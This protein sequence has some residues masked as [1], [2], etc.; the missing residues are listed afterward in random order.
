MTTEEDLDVGLFY[1]NG[2]GLSSIEV[3]AKLGQEAELHRLI[4]AV[5]KALRQGRAGWAL[6]FE[7]V[8]NN[9][10]GLNQLLLSNGQKSIGIPNAKHYYQKE[11]FGRVTDMSVIIANE[12][13]G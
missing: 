13:L 1:Y 7:S 2:V 11:I 8:E 12:L 9:Y 10:R 3:H 4:A 5:R 6:P